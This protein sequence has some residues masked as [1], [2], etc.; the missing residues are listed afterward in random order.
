MD[1]LYWICGLAMICIGIAYKVGHHAGHS[2]GM[3]DAME[4]ERK[5][6]EQERIR[7]W[8]ELSREAWENAKE[9]ADRKMRG[10]LV[11]GLTEGSSYGD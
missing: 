4:I 1:N 8:D 7:K 9:E 5:V 11:S 6:R 10:G 3:I 2:D